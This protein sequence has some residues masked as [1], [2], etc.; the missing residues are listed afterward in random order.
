MHRISSATD[1]ISFPTAGAEVALGL[2]G[3]V[4]IMRYARTV[5]SRLAVCI[6]AVAV[7]TVP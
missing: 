4:M 6:A 1:R 5:L 2:G 3:Q 7:I